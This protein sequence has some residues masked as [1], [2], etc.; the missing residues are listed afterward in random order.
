MTLR[1]EL[2]RDAAAA[3]AGYAET[4]T[5][6]RGVDGATVTLA[7]V[8]RD[9][10]SGA[11]ILDAGGEVDTSVFSLTVAKTEFPEVDGEQVFPQIGELVNGGEGQV[12]YVNGVKDPGAVRVVLLCGSFD[13]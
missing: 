9:N 11:E 4:C 13:R 12:K 2:A 10:P 5:W 3:V 6:V 8:R 7:C 1:E